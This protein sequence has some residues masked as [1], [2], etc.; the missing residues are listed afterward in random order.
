MSAGDPNQVAALLASITANL[1]AGQQ[2]QA[3][4]PQSQQQQHHQQPN[5]YHP[6]PQHLQGG[7]HAPLPLPSGLPQPSSSGSIDLSQLRPSSVGSMPMPGYDTRHADHGPGRYGQP[8]APYGD[9]YS[10]PPPPPRPY[11][12]GPDRYRERDPYAS[13]HARYD[14]PYARPPPHDYDPRSRSPR[15]G[16]D[17]RDRDRPYYS[18]DRSL[19]PP[20]RGGRGGGGGGGGVGYEEDS[21][22]TEDLMVDQGYVGLIIGKGGENL[23]RVEQTSGC[24][25]QF[26]PESATKPGERLA[27]L[28]GS[29]H[30]I[31]SARR[32]ID[33][34]VDENIAVKGALPGAR[35]QIRPPKPPSGGQYDNSRLLAE[36]AT[37]PERLV[38]MLVPDKTVGLIIGRGGENIKDLQAKSRAKINIVPES[39]SVNGH[40]PI[41]LLGE[42]EATAKA[43]QLILQ[44]VADDEAG[45]PI[46]R[47]PAPESLGAG[48]RQEVLRVPNDAVGMIIGKGGETVRDMQATT[49]CSIKVATSSDGDF[50]DITLTGTDPTIAHAKHLIN[51]KVMAATDRNTR[52]NAGAGSGANAY[53]AASQRPADYTQSYNSAAYGSNVAA[54]APATDDPYAPYGGYD[55]Y[56]KAW[57]QYQQ[58]QQQ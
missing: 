21:K 30:Q 13:H 25:V 2:G 51:E 5:P 32:M 17:P 40:R 9:A 24:K 56:I 49:T 14:D 20:R 22:V 1:K 8:P 44:I 52:G 46:S 11:E 27:F 39:Q 12:S 47:K 18:R 33:D 23:K 31:L 29:P 26:Q 34:I 55:A 50:R 6:A 28:I 41:N 54:A 57:Q 15:N 19:S 48:S 45:I 3:P 37:S 43:K 58:Q 38:Q 4:P 16:R 36:E 35:H 7:S 42:P 53:A 10:H